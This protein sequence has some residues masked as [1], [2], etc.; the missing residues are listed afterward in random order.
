MKTYKVTIT[1]TLEQEVEVQAASREEAERLVEMQWRN[2][3]H[4]LDSDNFMGVTFKAQRPQKERDF[5]R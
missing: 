2:E 5:N 4:I 1:E 3:D